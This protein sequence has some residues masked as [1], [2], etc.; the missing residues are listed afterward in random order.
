[1]KNVFYVLV[2]LISIVG[3]SGCESDSVENEIDQIQQEIE[4]IDNSSLNISAMDKGDGQ[5]VGT[6]Y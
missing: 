3:L 5:A 4:N 1:M 6:R 2:V